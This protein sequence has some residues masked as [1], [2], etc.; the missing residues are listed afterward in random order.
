MSTSD[1][2]RNPHG[3][4]FVIAQAALMLAVLVAPKL[5][6]RSAFWS[7]VTNVAGG[8]LCIVGLGFV[9]LGSIAQRKTTA[10][11]PSGTSEVASGFSGALGR[12]KLRNEAK[13][14]M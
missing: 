10:P 8:L 3:E 1:W 2:L 9:V 6:G 11:R 4:W 7:G 12:S 5:D 14:R 13:S